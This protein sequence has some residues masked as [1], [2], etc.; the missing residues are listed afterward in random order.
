MSHVETIQFLESYAGNACQRHPVC[1]T[2]I[3]LPKPLRS[4]TTSK[5]LVLGGAVVNELGCSKSSC[6]LAAPD[7]LCSSK[8]V[9]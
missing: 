8:S 2:P 6:K 1:Y 4:L 9:Q 7:I 3:L 5:Y